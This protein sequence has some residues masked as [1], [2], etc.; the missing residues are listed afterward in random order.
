MLGIDY[1]KAFNRLDH[2]ECLAQLQRLGASGASIN[3]VRS[4]LTGRSMRVRVGQ[5]MSACHSLKGGSPQGSILGCFLYCA[6]TQQ[7]NVDIPRVARGDVRGNAQGTAPTEP[8]AASSPDL[9][10]HGMGLMD[11]FRSPGS[12]D[13]SFR[14]AEAT[15]SPDGRDVSGVDLELDQDTGITTIIFKYVDD[16]TVV[17]SLPP[18]TS[19]RHISSAKPVEWLSSEGMSEFFHSLSSRAD[20]IGMRVNAKKTQL[21]CV[22][23]DNGY[24]SKAAFEV[25]EEG[26]MIESQ[27]TM[28]LLG[29]MLGTGPGASDHFELLR[30]KFRARFWA[31]IHLRRTGIRGMQLYRLYAALVRPV[32]E[33]NA[34]VY[35]PMLSVTQTEALERMQKQVFRLCFG[36]EASYARLL[37]GYQLET[38]AARRTK[39]VK[40]FVAKAM[41]NDRFA[42]RWFIRR[43][44]VDTEIRRRKPFV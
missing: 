41:T 20:E 14:T 12:S 23:P 25:G 44:G 33:A 10:D 6:T 9:P 38:L 42:G 29:Y 40:R 4:F 35:H 28:K 18:G 39:A 3:L 34:V 43:P 22:A 30:R 1:E 24:D 31:L 2:H 27:N 36:I 26:T 17:M 19:I 21:M 5:E 15:H 11:E 13:D 37:E 8:Q 16:T 7:I 32:L